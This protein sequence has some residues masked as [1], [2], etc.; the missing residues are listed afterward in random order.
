MLRDF[1]ELGA[2]QSTLVRAVSGCDDGGP[3]PRFIGL[4]A[5]AVGVLWGCWERDAL[6]DTARELRVAL[7][8]ASWT[9]LDAVLA[10][11]PVGTDIDDFVRTA[12]PFNF[13]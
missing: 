1:G 5:A 13:R 9:G 3:T 6:D 7:P 11:R 4:V 12:L 8:W 2:A 10:G